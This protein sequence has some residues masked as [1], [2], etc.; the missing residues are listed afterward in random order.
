MIRILIADN[1]SIFGEG[2][3]VILR[4]DP[5]LEIVGEAADGAEAIEKARYLRPNVVLM[6]QCL[7]N[8]YGIQI[9]SMIRSAAPETQVVILSSALSNASSV[10]FIRAG[11]SGYLF[12]DAQP[13]ELPTA[14]KAVAA[15]QMYICPQA[16]SRLQCIVA[17]PPHSRLLT[18]REM[19][20]LQLL[21]QGHCNRE[22]AYTLYVD[23]N[24]VKTHVHHILNKL[25]VRDRTQAILAALRLGLLE[26]EAMGV[27]LWTA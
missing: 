5:E 25:D 14:I 13:A 12:K 10:E 16:K 7:P 3:R 26:S 24:T 19:E 27:A 22:I 8:L 20:V 6:D 18:E 11:A 17:A 4:H 21:A 9:T 1:H 15:G 23:V 2:L